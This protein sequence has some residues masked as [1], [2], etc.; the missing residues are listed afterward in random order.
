M[1]R[2]ERG[3]VL[4]LELL[5]LASQCGHDN[6]Q[7]RDA[8]GRQENRPLDPD[9]FMLVF[10]QLREKVEN[11]DP[12]PIDGVEQGAE[13]NE[14]LERPVLV[15]IVQESPDTPAQKRHENMHGDEDSHAQSPDAVQDK[16]QIWTLPLISQACPQ[17]DISA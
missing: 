11:G 7:G 1:P 13:E 6:D 12:Q 2:L 15:N 10:D 4:G 14:Y 3:K 5:M 8:K 16:G 9:G 17:A